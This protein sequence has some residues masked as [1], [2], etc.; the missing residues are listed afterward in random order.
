M[1]AESQWDQ[2]RCYIGG[3]LCA[4]CWGIREERMP[5]LWAVIGIIDAVPVPRFVIKRRRGFVWPE[6]AE[7]V[8]DIHIF[9]VL[10]L[11]NGLSATFNRRTAKIAL[12]VC[13]D[14]DGKLPCDINK[15][16]L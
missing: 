12:F 15:I 16:G 4:K 8:C 13:L 14:D 10:F 2:F 9:D 3:V 6:G 5:R 7:D 11:L 1:D